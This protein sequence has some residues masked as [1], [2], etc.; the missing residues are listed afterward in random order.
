MS[1][2]KCSHG[3]IYH[4]LGKLSREKLK[5]DLILASDPNYAQSLSVHSFPFTS[6][7]SD[8]TGYSHENIE[9]TIPSISYFYFFLRI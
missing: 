7:L 4:P 2:F 6:Q 3:E 1:Y 9:E 5:R 8:L